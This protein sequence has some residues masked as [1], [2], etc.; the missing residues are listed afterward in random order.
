M[1]DLDPRLTPAQRVGRELARFRNQAGLTQARLAARLDVSPSLVAHVERGART[2][3]CD[4]AGKCDE[5]FK[6]D[7]RFT[8]LCRGLSASVLLPTWFA[9]W[10]D[11][12]EPRARVFRSWDPLLIPGFLQTEEYARA[13][14]RGH[15]KLSEEA[16]DKRVQARMMRNTL[17]TRDDPP[18]IWIPIDEGVLYRNIGGR[19]VMAAQLAHLL[20]VAEWRNVTLQVV[21]SD[22]P[23]TDGLLSAFTIAELDDAPTAVYVDSAGNGEVSTDHELVSLI[24][25][26]YDTLRAEAYRPIDSLAKIREARRKWTEDT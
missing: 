13:V 20:L 10:L 1:G 11:E 3:K 6:T 17:V 18:E 9:G 22:T 4:V 12:I 19:E 16:V 8:R 7:G 14:F 21:P 26:R 15:R 25:G 23:C 24:W 5:L 2:L